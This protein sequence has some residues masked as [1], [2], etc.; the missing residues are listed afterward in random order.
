MDIFNEINKYVSDNINNISNHM[1]KTYT[2]CNGLIE[3]IKVLKERNKELELENKERNN[4]VE[5]YIES[6]NKILSSSESCEYKEFK[7]IQEY[8]DFLQKDCVQDL[9]DRYRIDPNK[10][11]QLQLWIYQKYIR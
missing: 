9:C 3:K 7:I 2:Y 10:L 6:D 4:K 5:E 8:Y 1:E 11:S